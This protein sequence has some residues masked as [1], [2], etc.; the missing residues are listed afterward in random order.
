ML[1][2]ETV[3]TQSIKATYRLFSYLDEH[4]IVLSQKQKEKIDVNLLYDL[5]RNHSDCI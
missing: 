1:K 4:G 2:G 5:L 3:Q